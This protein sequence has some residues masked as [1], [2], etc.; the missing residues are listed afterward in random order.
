MA[1]ETI[2]GG[3]T[4]SPHNNNYE[5]LYNEIANLKG[6]VNNLNLNKADK[7]EIVKEIDLL[8][9]NITNDTADVIGA[10]VSNALLGLKQRIDN[11]IAQSGTSDTEVVDG[12]YDSVF[13]I[14]YPVLKDNMDAK[15]QRILELQ[16]KVDE[17]EKLTQESYGLRWNATTDTY[18]RIGAAKV[19][20]YSKSGGIITSD[21][22]NIYPWSE[23]KRCNLADDLT[24]NAYYGDAGYVED[25][26]NGQVMVEIPQF[27]LK[28]ETYIDSNGDKIHEWYISEFPRSGYKLHPTFINTRQNLIYSKVYMSAYEG[29][30]YDDSSGSYVG[31]GVVFDYTNDILASVSGLQPISGNS[32]SLTISQAR[33]LASNRGTGW[34]QQDILTLSAVQLLYLVE[35]ADFKSQDVLSYGILNLDSG[36]GNHSQNT[37]HT[38]TLGNQSG[39]VILSSLEN[40]AT[41]ASETYPMSYR[42]IENFYGNMWK[43]IDGILI[44]DDGIYIEDDMDNFSDSHTD[45]KF[46]PFDVN[47]DDGY[48]SDFESQEDS[49]ELFYPSKS[50]GG[51]TTYVGDYY[52]AHDAG[53]TNILLSGGAWFG[54]ALG[55]A[56]AARARSVA[57]ASYRDFAPRLVAKSQK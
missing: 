36:S 57:S 6:L 26:S 22:D 35:F 28:K 44:V 20:S 4:S 52:Y 49:D 53:E 38:S 54:S 42:G 43:F 25:G 16:N 15:S 32:D 37:G 56:F 5:E 3:V 47:L 17:L 7:N 2:G 18:T 12:R 21:F 8:A 23:M 46:I 40:G 31:D 13:D 1:R 34:T 27:W 50:T 41:G 14:T 19:K 10:K 24:V 39:E 9:S 29:T 48:I 11:I 30:I 51:S 55:G 33:Q 45:Y